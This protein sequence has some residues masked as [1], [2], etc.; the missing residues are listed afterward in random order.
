MTAETFTTEE[1][2]QDTT[3]TISVLRRYFREVPFQRMLLI[4]N[5]VWAALAAGGDQFF[6]WLCGKLA[7][8]TSGHECSGGDVL[9]QFGISLS[10]Q[11]LA[12]VALVVFL[13]RLIQWPVFEAGGQI[14]SMGL[15]TRMVGGVGR[16]RTTFFDEY[17]SGKVINRL[18]K[19][20]DQL[21]LYAPIR[22][23]DASS[24]L[25]ELVIL[26]IVISFASPLAAIVAI[27]AFASFMLIQRN[28]A[29]MLQKIMMLRSIRFGE[30]LHRESDIIDGV[31]CFELYGDLHSLLTRFSQA[32]YRYMQMHFLRGQIEAWGRFWCDVT[33]AVYGCITLT[34]VYVGI[35]YGGLSAIFGVM[36]VTAALRLGGLFGW[37]TW[38]LGSLFETA[39]HARRVFE[40]VDLPSEETE[41][42]LIPNQAESRSQES[43]GDLC[44][45]N[46]TMSYRSSTPTILSN[47]SVK[48]E[49]NSK[50]GLVGRTG[51]GKTS[52]VQALF[53]MVYVRGGDIQ[54]GGRSLLSLPV[55]EARACFSIVPQDPYLFEGTVR[56]NLDRYNEHDDE[57][58]LEALISVQLS[59]DLSMELHEGGTNLSLGQRQLL[60]LARV[61][62]SKRPFVI[63]DEPTSG[64]DTITD[65]VM[66]S[67]LRAALADKTGITI[68]HRL[69]TLAR[70]DRVIELSDGKILRDGKPS[71]ILP[72]LAH[73][74]LA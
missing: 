41:E 37:L 20:A 52:F 14:F 12:L 53:R 43:N 11:T 66:Q 26:A 71:E 36:I 40:Y 65:A 8:C 44:F 3:G 5:L 55:E 21:R 6:V 15:F 61:I 51:A 56:S 4:P 74:E 46:Y 73:D 68:A 10:L 24:A 50:V 45:L 19:D 54:L 67:V 30:V 59:L 25:V 72:F 28:I 2:S 27:P 13:L 32:V 69:E 9:S 22:I 62:I 35:H 23:G 7:E 17:P 70:M 33:V 34:A 64:V 57:A 38:S 29:P 58:L 47:F 18:I 1:V 42:G 31:R 39:G 16:V 60:C 49:K 48:I 63:M